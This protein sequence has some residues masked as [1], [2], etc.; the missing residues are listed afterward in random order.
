MQFEIRR[1]RIRS[2][3]MSHCARLDER[4]LIMTGFKQALSVFLS[5]SLMLSVM[6]LEGC[7]K[8]AEQAQ[9]GE[10]QQG[11]APATTYAVPT[12]D[13]LYQLVAP[14]ALFPDNLVAI[15]L[16]A[17]TYPDQVTDAWNWM[18]QNGGLQGAQLMQAVDQQN[19]DVSV[20]GLTEFSDVLQQ[21][22]TNL[23]WTSSLGD[24]YFNSPQNVMN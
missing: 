20:K 2:R 23:T 1:A 18:Q 14:I 5:I 12:A 17:S 16:A 6:G 15:V 21:M 9:P 22:A 24:A 13:Q 4:G 8:K 3:I 7:K 19:W 11:Q 10:T